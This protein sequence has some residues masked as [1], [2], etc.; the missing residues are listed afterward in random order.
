MRSLLK[1]QNFKRKFNLLSLLICI[2]ASIWSQNLSIIT[3]T[4][5]EGKSNEPIP[6]ATICLLRNSNNKSILITGTVS[7][8]KGDFSINQV[9]NGDYQLKVTSIGYKMQNLEISVPTIKNVGTVALQDSS[10]SIIEAVVVADRIKAKSETDKTIYYVNQK[11]L[12]ATGN[13][14]DLL[15][16]I[17]GVQV[18]LKQNISVEGQ[19]NIMLFVDGKER[20]KSYISQLVPSR[21][22]KVEV[23]TTPPANYDGNASGVI[24]IVLK[25]EKE[26]GLSGNTFS[27]IPV[28]TDVVYMFPTYSLNYNYNKINLYTSYNG[29]INFE[30]IEEKTTRQITGNNPITTISSLESVRQKNLSHKFHYGVDYHFSA[31]DVVN[32]YGFYNQYSYEQDGDVNVK[33]TGNADWEAYKEET[34]KNRN[35]FNSLYYKHL[36]DNEEKTLTIDLSHAII[37]SK[38][39]VVFENSSESQTNTENPKQNTTMV[40]ADFKMP[41]NEK[42]KWSTGIKIKMRD[43][44]DDNSDGFNYDKQVYAIYGA[45]IYKNSNFDLNIGLRAEQ[46]ETQ[47]NRNQNN[48]S[49]SL[50]PYVAFHYK[51]GKQNHLNLSLR[52]SVNRP[53]VYQLNPYFYVAN[54]YFILKGNPLLNPEFHNRLILEYATRFKSNYMSAQLFYET[55]SNAINN[56]T[57]LNKRNL[58]VSQLQ[59]LGDIHQYG[60]QLKGALKFGILSINPSLRVYHQSTFGNDFAK[61][62][63]VENKDNWVFESGISSVLSLKRDFALSFIFQYATAKENIQDNTYFNPL[64]F[65]SLDKTI[66]KNLKIGI[67]SAL[68]FAKSFVYQGADIKAPNFTSEYTGNLKLPVVP[69]MFRLSY[70]FNTGKNRKILNREKEQ[71]DT[72]QK[73]GF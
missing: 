65:I 38:N 11:M 36:F 73:Q 30:D 34:D 19:S 40:K 13:A 66:Q 32:F 59:N 18:D 49:F 17:P 8:N 3:G 70:R 55:E 31:K 37:N 50:L 41:I 42:I 71:V 60:L 4:I 67:V 45:L 35:I 62:H 6:F 24:N 12:S 25:K 33:A 61:H 23:L 56:F 7:D 14:P 72:R 63:A 46:S 51:L 21:I 69:L 39:Q 20:D 52:R 28:S 2:S 1:P 57:S 64:Y 47:L 54:P 48:S 15:R 68:P 5:V 43:M 10:Y 27:E 26:S 16:H 29:E 53:T 44:Q 22:D 58:F 9:A